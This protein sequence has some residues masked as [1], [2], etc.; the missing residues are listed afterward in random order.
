MGL[1]KPA[2]NESTVAQPRVR[3]G[4]GERPGPAHPALKRS[5]TIGQPGLVVVELAGCQSKIALDWDG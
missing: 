2:L 1:L 3:Q 4:P 5:R